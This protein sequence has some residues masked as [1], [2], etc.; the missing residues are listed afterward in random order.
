MNDGALSVPCA[1]CGGTGRVPTTQR[2]DDHALFVPKPQH[3]VI[4]VAQRYG[5]SHLQLVGRGRPAIIRRPR[6]I[7]MWLLRTAAGLSLPEIGRIFN[8]A[9]HTSTVT[10]CKRV[11]TERAVSPAFKKET[12][13]LVVA[14]YA[15]YPALRAA[16]HHPIAIL[17]AAAQSSAD[18]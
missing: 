11:R 4:F 8:K 5:V 16:S 7:A 12:D 18:A 2:D 9:D 10:A 14:L 3:I 13:D 15:H 17:V 1:R 6:R